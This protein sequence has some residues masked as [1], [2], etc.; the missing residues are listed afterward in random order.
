MKALLRGKFIALSALI[1][2][3][4]NSHIN[5]LKVYLRVQ[6]KKGKR[7]KYTKRSRQQEIMKLR[8]EIVN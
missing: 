6:G 3:L 7:N 4:K 8:A 5:K 1:K 2:K